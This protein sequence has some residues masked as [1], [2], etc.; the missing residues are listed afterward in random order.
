[1]LTNTSVAF[2]WSPS[3]KLEDTHSRPPTSSL[4][5]KTGQHVLL[6]DDDRNMAKG[7]IEYLAP[8]G[9][10][11]H[12]AYSAKAG[13]GRIKKGGLV[14][15]ILDVML[16]DRDGLSVLSEIRGKSHIPVIVLTAK[17]AVTDKVAGLEAGADDYIPKPFTAAELLARI[18]TVLRRGQ[19]TGTACLFLAVDD[20][21]LDSGSRT[22]ERN[23]ERIE[24]TTAEFSALHTLVSCLGTVITRE[25][26]TRA[27]L[28]RPHS[29][30]DRGVDNL[31]S[32]LR[33]KVGPGPNGQDRFRSVRSTGYLY[34]R[35][36]RPDVKESQQSTA[37]L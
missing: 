8:E 13:L 11:L 32:A 1:V 15:V 30:T 18:R 31:I 6:I 10:S 22:V 24:C 36:I 20:L 19:P 9:Y 17:A 3:V 12:V 5:I 37:P 26:L 21:I 28:G 16:P 4:P 14:L 23:G 29:A 33:K 2:A 35:S 34:V 25:Q 27:A 7:L